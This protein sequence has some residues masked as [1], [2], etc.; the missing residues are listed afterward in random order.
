[1]YPEPIVIPFGRL[2]N[3]QYTRRLQ[4]RGV[5]MFTRVGLPQFSVI[6]VVL[7]LFILFTQR[8]RF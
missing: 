1:M 6:V 2:T 4:R 3:G 7:I 5:P 8:H